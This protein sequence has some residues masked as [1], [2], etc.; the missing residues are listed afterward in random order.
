M[1]KVQNGTSDE[2]SYRGPDVTV[3]IVS[4]DGAPDTRSA[5][6]AQ[7]VRFWRRGA[8]VKH[9]I[10]ILQRRVESDD[11]VIRLLVGSVLPKIKGPVVVMRGNDTALHSVDLSVWIGRWVMSDV[12]IWCTATRDDG[13]ITA[14]VEKHVLRRRT[15]SSAVLQPTPVWGIC[16][17]IAAAMLS[18]LQPFEGLKGATMSRALGVLAGRGMV[19]CD[20]TALVDIGLGAPPYGIHG[21][22]ESA[23]ELLQQHYVP[24]SAWRYPVAHIRTALLTKDGRV[25]VG[26]MAAVLLL[27]VLMIVAV[28]G[29]IV[30]C[31]SRKK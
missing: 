26:T 24:H 1:Q 22:N 28:V 11:D 2:Y 4:V 7:A 20:T 31:V 12:P 14:W 19:C 6:L 30:G 29:C 27:A 13:A 25:I 15:N 17:G 9:R 8:G 5:W 18:L 3:V 16:S 10:Q 21:V 23:H